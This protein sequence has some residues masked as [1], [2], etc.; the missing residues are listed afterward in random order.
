MS[1]AAWL[2]LFWSY[3]LPSKK[4]Y[5]P[6]IYSSNV[7]KKMQYINEVA[8][9]PPARAAKRNW[10]SSHVNSKATAA[11]PLLKARR[12]PWESAPP[13]SPGRAQAYVDQDLSS[14]GLAAL[15]KIRA[16]PAARQLRTATCAAVVT[17]SVSGMECAP[18]AARPLL[19]S[20]AVISALYSNASS[21]CL[22]N[23]AAAALAAL[24]AGKNRRRLRRVVATG[25]RVALCADGNDGSCGMARGP[26]DALS[27]LC[28]EAALLL[29][30]HWRDEALVG[31]WAR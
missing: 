2:Y 23:H 12:A 8:V 17:L 18:S 5:R 19:L 25:W 10:S 11:G 29:L 14:G 27:V 26:Q 22:S 30:A 28:D 31:C 15:R 21:L 20:T 4:L 24:A 9:V 3:K 6:G 13:P 16:S 7:T 1:Q